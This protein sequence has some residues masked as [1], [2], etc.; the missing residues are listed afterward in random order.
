MTGT[1]EMTGTEEM[2][3][4]DAVSETEGL[5]ETAG[6]GTSELAGTAWV[7]TQTQM[8]D[9]SVTT[10]A[11]ADAVQRTLGEDGS[12]STTTDCNSFNG[13]YTVDGNQIKID[14]PIST[15]MACPDGA[16]EADYIKD[17]TSVQSFLFSDG[18]LVLELPFD[19]GGMI[20]APAAQ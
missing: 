15:R 6:A 7:W 20:F 11:Q 17:L 12:A 9:D 3:A 16:Q 10:P 1:T 14:L 8:N 4:T 19:S 13:T 5:T 18:N 2:T